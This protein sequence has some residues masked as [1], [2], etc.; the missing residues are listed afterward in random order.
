VTVGHHDV[1]TFPDALAARAAALLPDEAW[2]AASPLAYQLE[3]YG[4][5]SHPLRRD[6]LQVRVFLALWPETDADFGALY[7]NG[8]DQVSH[9]YWPFQDAGVQRRIRQ[10]P[11]AHLEAVRKLL[12]RHPGRALPPYGDIGLGPD[13][14]SEAARWVPDYYRYLDE[15]LGRVRAVVGGDTTLVLASDH[16]FQVSLSKPLVDGQHRDTAVFAAVGPQVRVGAVG[17]V[18]IGDV[19]PTLYALLGLP[20]AKDMTGKVAT[21]LFDVT[22]RP[23]IQ[24]RTLDRAAIEVGAG[25]G[26]AGDDALRAQLEA[27][28]YLDEDGRPN[29]A[30]GG[31]RV[32]VRGVPAATGQTDAP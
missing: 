1:T 2:L 27:L 3:Q 26:T 17:Q 29:A 16:G 14:L 12:A 6:E 22:E 5:P 20:A 25:S 32:R 10:D 8:A 11:G 19:A 28:G 23:R 4:A 13:R 31:S 18:H 24:T 15:V 7:L 30:I 9:L 21:E